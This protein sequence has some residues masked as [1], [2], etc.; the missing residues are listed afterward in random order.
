MK[1]EKFKVVITGGYS[2]TAV[3]KNI[4]N[5]WKVEQ[6]SSEVFAYCRDCGRFFNGSCPCGGENI[7]CFIFGLNEEVR[8]ALFEKHNEVEFFIEEKEVTEEFIEA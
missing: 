3:Y 1:K 4:D 6:F 2:Y 7:K 8:K 5:I